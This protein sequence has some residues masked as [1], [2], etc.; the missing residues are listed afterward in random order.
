[1]KLKEDERIDEIGFG[2]LRL[3]Q[4]PQEF[5]YG[6]D[7][8]ILADFAAKGGYRERERF[9][10]N[11][12]VMADLGTGTGIIPLILSHKTDSRM[13]F[14]LEKQD[15]VCEAA[16]RNTE[17]NHL[18]DRLRIFCGGVEDASLPAALK[19]AA[20]CDGFDAVTCNPPYVTAGC[21]PINRNDAKYIA[22]HETTGALEDFIAFAGMLLKEK[23]DFYMVHRPAR[24]V[25]I[26]CLCR[27]YKLE[28]KA[29]RFVS[30]NRK[31][32]PNILLLHC[33]KGAGRELRLLDPLYVYEE[34]GEYSEE[35]Q[36]IYERVK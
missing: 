5:C 20:A 26:L 22:R 28:P 19:A 9:Y 11:R 2:T 6:V 10:G 16:R 32:A 35:I 23:G 15:D 8:V 13:I 21:G 30:P 25:D 29:L 18:A 31:A 3:I 7:A 34:E 17:L 24:I 12:T 4:R 33:I 1:M 36:R 14:G 27:A